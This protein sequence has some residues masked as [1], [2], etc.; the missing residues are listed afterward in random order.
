M[1]NLI[2]WVCRSAH[3]M[4]VNFLSLCRVYVAQ[5]VWYSSTLVLRYTAGKKISVKASLLRI[6]VHSKIEVL[7]LSCLSYSLATIYAVVPSSAR[8]FKMLPK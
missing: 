6:L 2:G 3:R 8:T 4:Y 5:R 1:Q 7:S